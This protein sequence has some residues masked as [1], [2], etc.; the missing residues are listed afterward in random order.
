MGN[1]GQWY[2][3]ADL[4]VMS[5]RFEG[6]PN[7][8]IEA[9]AH[10]LASVSFDCDSGPREIIRHEI[11]GLLV[12]PGDAKAFKGALTRL[13]Q[14]ETLRLQYAKKAKETRQRFSI[15]K[16]AARWEKLFREVIR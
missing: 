13:M 3:A 14:D 10:G 16:I 11:D 2:E 1:I 6:F 15:D 8:L 12:P 5:S 4:F 7:A 9:M